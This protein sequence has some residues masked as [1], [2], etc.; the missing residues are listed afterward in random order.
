MLTRDSKNVLSL[1]KATVICLCAGVS[2]GIIELILSNKPLGYGVGLWIG[3][4]AGYWMP[5]VERQ[6]D[7]KAYA[8]LCTLLSVIGGIALASILSMN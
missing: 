2:A 4:L 3:F 8:L 6:M 7:F 5:P 1:K